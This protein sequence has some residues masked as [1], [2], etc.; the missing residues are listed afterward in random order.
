MSAMD[1]WDGDT[2]IARAV[3]DRDVLGRKPRRHKDWSHRRG[4]P[5]VLALLWTCYLLAVGALMF[6]AGA[7]GGTISNA[8]YR[9]AA[10]LT[11]VLMAVGLV[12]LWPAVRL[13]QVVPPEGGRR[14]V[15]RDLVVLLL[16]AQALIWPQIWLA[17]W[18]VATVAALSAMLAVWAGLLGGVLAIALGCK[19]KTGRRSHGEIPTAPV[20]SL[21]GSARVWWMIVV[22][23]IGLGG[24]WGG[25]IET[26][27]PHWGGQPRWG[28]MLS[29]MTG[30]YELTHD[31]P[32]LGQRAL[33]TGL[34]W[35]MI[36]GVGTAA[37]VV[38]IGGMTRCALRHRGQEN[39]SIGRDGE[40]RWT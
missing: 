13:C 25:I 40:T 17:Q 21:G 16:P 19:A 2:P 14:A 3:V 26:G 12:V 6:V 8:T 23:V 9:P 30:V 5:R 33:P 15:V 10:R 20:P 39:A 27:H 34:H 1:E 38:W 7:S 37:L 31:R 11:L 35:G 29:P 22:L 36:G 4:E 24:A 18:S 32:W 28:W